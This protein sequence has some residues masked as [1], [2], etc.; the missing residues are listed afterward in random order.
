MTDRM[1]PQADVHI[2]RDEQG[3]V[4]AN[5]KHLAHHSPSGFE[6][7]YH[8]SGP[9]DLALSILARFVPLEAGTPS[10][11][12]YRGQRCSLFAWQHHQEFKREFI[13]PLG[14]A[15]GVIPARD[16]AAWIDARRGDVI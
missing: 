12:L 13:A 16:I 8:G 10:E 9:A 7:G 6:C 14:S 1:G 3:T 5:V 11:R 2:W 4:K 15:G